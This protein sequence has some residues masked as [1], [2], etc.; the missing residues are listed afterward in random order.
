MHKLSILVFAIA[1][2]FGCSDDTVGGSTN[3]GSNNGANNASNNGTNNGS[4]TNNANNASD[5]GVN[6]ASDAGTVNNAS[7]MATASDLPF[8]QNDAGQVLC[9]DAPCECSDGIDNDGDGFIDGFDVECTGPYDDD[10]GSFATGIP[11][12]NKDPIWQDCFFDGNSG[13]GDDGCRYR[14][15]CLTGELDPSDRDCQ[16]S[17][18]CIDFCQRYAPNGCDCFGCCEVFTGDGSV[19]VQIG[20]TCSFEEIDDEAACPRCV[21]NTECVNT[22]GTCELCAG[23]TVDDLPAECF[24]D[25]T[26]PDMGTTGGDMGTTGDMGGGGDE[27]VYTCDNGE[28]VCSADIP[29][30]DPNQYCSLGCCIDVI[31]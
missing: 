13:S 11:G 29:C 24:D 15:G 23:K 19:F 5:G 28:Q 18:Q 4:G 30:T 10:E 25:S 14:T 31:L 3:N 16:L 12:D 8:T 21:Q 17:Q 2:A 6:N 22:C 7:D 27:P 26:D 1:L 9:G 20:N